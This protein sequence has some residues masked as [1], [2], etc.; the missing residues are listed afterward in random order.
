MTNHVHLLLTPE[1]ADGPSRLMQRV[2]QRYVQ[3]VNRT[4]QRTGTLWE[5]RF[6]SCLVDA[7]AYLLACQR[8]IELNPVRA[9][10][11]AHPGDYPWS[12]YRENAQGEGDGIVS[13]HACYQALGR[14]EGERQGNYRA[15][16]GDHLERGL[17]DAIRQATHG[18]YCLG[19][20][21]FKQEVAEVLKR[22]VVRGQAGGPKKQ[23]VNDTPQ[24]T[25]L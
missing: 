7:E 18:G 22:R 14:D 23:E 13:P 5:G 19:S 11:V 15:L 12:S 25:L 10:M 17:L 3:Y 4:Y 9:Q 24:G 16:F 21:R 6:R 1:R 2:A 20:D 8:Y